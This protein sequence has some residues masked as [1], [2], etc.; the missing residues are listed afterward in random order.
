MWF[1]T[2]IVTASLLLGTS[3]QAAAPRPTMTQRLAHMDNESRVEFA[4]ATVT[5]NKTEARCAK[6]IAYKESRYR[7]EALNKSSGA[8]G[9]WQL[10]WGKPHWNI[11]KQ[12]QEANK[13]VLHRYDSWCGA[14][15]FHQERNWF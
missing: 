8:R 14:Y 5:G 11:L 9:V 13:Y 3:A 1:I 15:R 10:L 2:A 4:I 12:V 6:Q 7:V